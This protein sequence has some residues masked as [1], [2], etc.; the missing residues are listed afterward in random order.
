MSSMMF[1]QVVVEKRA[2][3]RDRRGRLRELEEQLAAEQD[4]LEVEERDL[5]SLLRVAQSVGVVIPDIE[6]GSEGDVWLLKERTVAVADVLGLN[7]DP[8]SPANVAEILR[9][10]GRTD[11]AEQVSATLAHLKRS[12]RAVLVG[13]AQWVSSKSPLAP[14]SIAA[15][16]V[17]TVESAM[18]NRALEGTG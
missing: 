1:E 17:A 5:E 18:G 16:I 12:N 7:I 8:L 15:A 14:P 6:E 10:Y 11:D 13:R 9:G 2:Q 3:V 4:L